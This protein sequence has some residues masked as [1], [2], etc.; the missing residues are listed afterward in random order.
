MANVNVVARA[1]SEGERSGGGVN[2]RL[3]LARKSTRKA[4]ALVFAQVEVIDAERAAE[5]LRHNAGNR[6]LKR[7]LIARLRRALEEGRFLMNGESIVIDRDGRLLDGQHRLQAVVDTGLTIEA[8]LV[9]NVDQATFPTLDSGSARTAGDV[10]GIAGTQN[11]HR[12]S[13]AVRWIQA[14]RAGVTAPAN[15]RIDADQVLSFVEGLND[16]EVER[17]QL[18]TLAA[19]R[20]ARLV[21][22]SI[23]T[24]LSFLFAE[25]DEALALTFF[26]DLHSGVGLAPGDPVLVLRDQLARNSAAKNRLA[27]KEIFARCIRAWNARRAGD[28][29]THL[30]GLVAGKDGAATMPRIR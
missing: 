16:S 25:K 19:G 7:A 30:K 5:L 24:A 15:V 18:A 11:A 27:P 17:M 13:A 22:G 20:V 1:F 26:D 8:L 9:Y 12:I 28:E 6:H 14:Y 4:Y 10:L 21:A 23:A 3:R 29:V 2:P